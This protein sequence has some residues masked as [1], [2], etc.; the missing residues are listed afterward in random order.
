MTLSTPGATRPRPLCV[1]VSVKGASGE[2]AVC[3]SLV[4]TIQLLCLC[5]ALLYE[6]LYI[7]VF[8]VEEAELS[9]AAE[10]FR[11]GGRRYRNSLSMCSD[12]DVGYE[13]PEAHRYDTACDAQQETEKNALLPVADGRDEADVGGAA[14]ED[15]HRVVTDDA[16]VRE[17]VN[18]WRS[19]PNAK[20]AP[21]CMPINVKVNYR[22]EWLFVLLLK[23]SLCCF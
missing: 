21:D 18:F 23:E 12:M 15:K 22:K 17:F 7:R 3:P 16:K 14:V 4:T 6:L 9:Q 1:S 2:G 10:A 20:A 13:T 5:A 8:G 19:S 11:L